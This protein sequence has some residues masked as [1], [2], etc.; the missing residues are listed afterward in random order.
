MLWANDSNLETVNAEHSQA[1]VRNIKHVL[2]IREGTAVCMTN[3]K[4]LP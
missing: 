4:T 1:L 3:I 2:K